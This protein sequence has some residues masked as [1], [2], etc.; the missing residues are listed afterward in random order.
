MRIIL[1]LVVLAVVAGMA[2]IRLA[3]TTEEAWHQRGDPGASGD[4]PRTG[5]FEAVRVVEDPEAMLTRLDEIALATPRTTRFAGSVEEGMIT[6]ETRSQIMGF[7]DYTT[8]YTA[9]G[10][11]DEDLLVVNG[12]LRFGQSDMGVNE[13]R[14][15]DWL[16]QLG[17]TGGAS[18][19]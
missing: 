14:V 18:P 15:R 6:Y 1:I 12:R 9:Q 16:D 10:E 4:Y 3:P 19:S 8:V 13:A 7:P 5:G 17:L 11:G 2:Y